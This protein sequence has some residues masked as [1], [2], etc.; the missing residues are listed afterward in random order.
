MD[1]E[2][3]AIFYGPREGG[4]SAS[5]HAMKMVV[6]VF[7]AAA[8]LVLCA[9][10][11]DV[12]QGLVYDTAP[13]QT[14]ILRGLALCVA[15]GLIVWAV[16]SGANVSNEVW[17]ERLVATLGFARIHRWWLTGAAAASV[18]GMLTI[19]VPGMGLYAVL[20][21]IVNT[22]VARRVSWDIPHGDTVWPTAIAYSL[23]T[24][25]IAFAAYL[26]TRRLW[27]LPRP[28]V[29]ATGTTT[30]TFFVMLVIHVVY[31]FANR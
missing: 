16:H 22:L 31:R 8:A 2:D 13:R 18:I 21:F 7:G 23:A 1:R 25:W 27:T 5:V 20:D 29:V 26:V 17:Q 9:N 11:W 6:Y 4:V 10:L 19:G 3:D 15:G 24:P 28:L 30:A 12:L 14:L